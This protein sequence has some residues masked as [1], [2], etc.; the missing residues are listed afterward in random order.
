MASAGGFAGPQVPVPA[1]RTFERSYH[2]FVATTMD[3][4]LLFSAAI[5][6]NIP[7][8]RRRPHDKERDEAI[9]SG[10]IFIYEE[11][12]SGVKRW[13]DGHNWS[14]S[15]IMGDYLIYR[16]LIQPFP[17]GEKKKAKKT[18]IKNGV[19]KPGSTSRPQPQVQV[20]QL[21]RAVEGTDFFSSQVGHD[22]R[23]DQPTEGVQQG[24]AAPPETDTMRQL[25]GSLVDSYEFKPRGLVKK[26]ISL[27]IHNH[28]FHLVSYYSVEDVM[29]GILKTPESDVMFQGYPLNPEVVAH[30]WKVPPEPADYRFAFPPQG[31]GPVQLPDQAHYPQPMLQGPVPHA[32]THSH[33]QPAMEQMHQGDPTMQTHG[34]DVYQ[35]V[36]QQALAGQGP[37]FAQDGLPSYQPMQQ[38]EYAHH[39]EY[40]HQGEYDG[41]NGD[42][43]MWNDYQDPVV[44]GYNQSL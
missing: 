15:R 32:L 42:P 6:G 14:P 30:P 38:A 36:H 12:A 39:G 20:A 37:V 11:S 4:I 8:V 26:T 28:H 9:R 40:A 23:F 13:T 5:D 2:G 1:P 24:P 7:L 18:V 3:A 41:H 43:R 21:A 27:K 16:E 29:A 10:N 44:P 33:N 34:H 17:A 35:N 22:V 31:M 25:V 19:N